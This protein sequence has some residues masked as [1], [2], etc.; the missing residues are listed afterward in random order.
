MHIY[1]K[2]WRVVRTVKQRANEGQAK[3]TLVIMKMDQLRAD[4]LNSRNNRVCYAMIEIAFIGI[5]L[6][7]LNI[8]VLHGTCII[9]EQLSL[10]HV[11]HEQHAVQIALIQGPWQ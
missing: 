11:V 2:R 5:N 6:Q 4:S 8:K 1:I 3:G 9:V 10:I 7:H